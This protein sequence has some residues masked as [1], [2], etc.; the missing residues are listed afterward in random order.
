VLPETAKLD[1]EGVTGKLI[2]EGGPPVWLKEMVLP[3]IDAEMIGGS[4]PTTA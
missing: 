3:K 4:T 1:K 2:D